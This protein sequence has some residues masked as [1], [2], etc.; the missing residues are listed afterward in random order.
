[1]SSDDQIR[2]FNDIMEDDD[3]ADNVVDQL[4]SR[5]HNPREAA[6]YLLESLDVVIRSKQP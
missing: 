3:S 5:K 1:M 4:A 2:S 6:R